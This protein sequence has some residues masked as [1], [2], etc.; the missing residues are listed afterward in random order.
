MCVYNPYFV[1]VGLLTTPIELVG[2]VRIFKFDFDPV[3]F[4]LLRSWE[5]DR[6]E[7][8][9]TTGNG[10]NRYRSGTSTI[11]LVFISHLALSSH[12]P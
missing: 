12:N 5:Y 3:P 8:T 6:I 1:F 9:L 11:F 7:L 4:M 10:L 2:E